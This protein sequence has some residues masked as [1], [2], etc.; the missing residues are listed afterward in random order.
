MSQL[1]R[2]R[3]RLTVRGIAQRADV[4]ATF[5]YENAETRALVQNAITTSRSRYDRQTQ[6]Q[7]DPMELARTR[8]ER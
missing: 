3:G 8:M 4:S 2:E 5:L 1:R 6:Q 7:H